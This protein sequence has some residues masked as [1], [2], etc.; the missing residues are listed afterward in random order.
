MV[1]FGGRIHGC[2]ELEASTLCI[3]MNACN[4]QVP[5]SYIL[6]NLWLLYGKED[7]DLNQLFVFVACMD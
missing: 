1:T 3:C 6:L 4:S 7:D 2:D 5:N